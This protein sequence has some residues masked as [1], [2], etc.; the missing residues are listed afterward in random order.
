MIID[1][2]ENRGLY[3]LPK[4][5]QEALD[6]FASHDLTELEVGKYEL[7]NGLTMKVDEYVPTGEERS[8]EGHEAISHL[9]YLV[10]GSERLG[11]ANKGEMTF[12]ELVKEDKALYAGQGSILRITPGTFVVLYPQD[13]HML[14]L[15]DGEQIR[16]R[17][18]SVSLKG[19][20]AL[21]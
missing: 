20:V 12:V 13:C 6:Y 11:Y 1:K 8:Y 7:P 17:K 4:Q 19:E 15:K 2:I 5:M 16:V 14:K 21:S 3:R 10:S 18:V 9:R